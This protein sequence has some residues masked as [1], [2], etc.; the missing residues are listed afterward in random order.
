MGSRCWGCGLGP[1]VPVGEGRIRSLIP[2][3]SPGFWNRV[4]AGLCR[5][6]CRH[7]CRR[8]LGAARP[9]YLAPACPVGRRGTRG[10]PTGAAA[11]R[12]ERAPPLG[13]RGPAPSR[14][15]SR[16]RFRPGGTRPA[17]SAFLFYAGRTWPAGGTSR[18]GRGEMTAPRQ[19]GFSAPVLSARSRPGGPGGAG[20]PHAPPSPTGGARPPRGRSRLT[21]CSARPC[22]CM[23]SLFSPCH[24]GQAA[25]AHHRLL[26]ALRAA[27][28]LWSQGREGP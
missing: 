22:Q 24:R 13:T 19:G 16:P 15:A 6:L 27:T 21:D 5:H 23:K 17:A 2:V 10:W 9:A 3:T 8:T 7:L 20:G 4:R 25:R 18:P 28:S 1:P 11:W 14:G 12:P 26:Q